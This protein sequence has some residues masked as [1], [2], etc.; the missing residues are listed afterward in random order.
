MGIGVM[1]VFKKLLA[2]AH[3]EVDT[4]G[5]HQTPPG[6]DSNPSITLYKMFHKSGW[7]DTQSDFSGMFQ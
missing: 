6:N 5:H 2:N 7:L 1:T 3:Q 4:T